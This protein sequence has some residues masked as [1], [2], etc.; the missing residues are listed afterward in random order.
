MTICA[1]AL[2]YD[3]DGPIIV[4]AADTRMSWGHDSIDTAVK[5]RRINSNWIAC[6]SADDIS[7]LETVIGDLRNAIGKPD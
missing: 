4:S 7:T 1:A 5:A 2:A 6:F 3:S